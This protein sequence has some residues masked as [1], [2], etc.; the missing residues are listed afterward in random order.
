M[1]G[2]PT[3][4]G[5]DEA[6]EQN[7]RCMLLWHSL[8]HW[9]QLQFQGPT[10]W[11]TSQKLIH[12]NVWGFQALIYRVVIDALNF[13]E[14]LEPCA[15]GGSVEPAQTFITIESYST[16]LFSMINLVHGGD[17]SFWDVQEFGLIRESDWHGSIYWGSL[18]D[19]HPVKTN[20]QL[21]WGHEV[22][23]SLE[24]NHGCHILPRK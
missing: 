4:H 20:E 22:Q 9:C 16:K 7:S 5:C 11:T 18:K 13:N 6:F 14:T 12:Y 21:N 1:L 2:R 15:S 10:F 3:L 19:I 23:C 8:R 24:C 17:S